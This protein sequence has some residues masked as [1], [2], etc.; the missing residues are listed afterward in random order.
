MLAIISVYAVIAAIV[1]VSRDMLLSEAFLDKAALADTFGLVL[2]ALILLEFSHSVYVSLTERSG[3]IQARNLV[4]ITILV[5]ARK[6][7][8]MDYTAIDAQ[9]LLGFGAL[10]LAL[11]GLY[12]MISI[13]HHP[14]VPG[15]PERTGPLDRLP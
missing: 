15:V 4:L 8:L 2:T 12:W 14:E 9:T 3:A 13:G 10:L 6:L 5:V 7:I 1:Q 11:G